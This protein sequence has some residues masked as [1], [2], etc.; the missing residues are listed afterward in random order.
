MSVS[1]G[2]GAPKRVAIEPP[3]DPVLDDLPR[4][5][6]L[7]EMVREYMEAWHARAAL[8]KRMDALGRKLDDPVLQ[9]HPSWGGA[10]NRHTRMEGDRKSLDRHIA[11]LL[12]GIRGNWDA[13]SPGGRQQAKRR[14]GGT[15]ERVRDAPARGLQIDT[16]E[17]PF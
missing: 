1:F 17:A 13:L 12:A 8:E 5:V 7:D 6:A 10:W 3:A 4:F 15:W 16:I 9:D 2:S 14:W 11:W